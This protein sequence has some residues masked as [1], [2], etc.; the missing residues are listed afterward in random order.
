MTDVVARLTASLADRYRIERELGAG[1][2]ATVYLAY[3][4]RHE[5]RVALK[6]LRP[7]LAAVIGADRF[8]AE[9][10][11]TAHLQHAHILGLIDSGTVNGTVFYVMPF[12]EGESLRDRLDREKQLPVAD[13]VRIATTVAG[14]LDYAHRRGVI[15]RDIKPANILLH[16]GQALIADFGIALAITRTDTTTTGSRMT[17]TG[18]SLGTPQY[19]SPEQAMGERN[20]DAR[21][22]IYSL[23]CVLYE[24][25]SGEPPFSGPTAQAVF[26]KVMG[27]DP[28]PVT[29]LRRSVPANVGAATMTALNK[30]P[31]DRFAT[32]AEFSE[33]LGDARYVGLP[34]SRTRATAVAKPATATIVTSV[35]LAI[36][37][38]AAIAGWMRSSVVVK[39]LVARFEVPLPASASP[40]QFVVS[41]DGSRIFWGSGDAYFERRLDSL[42]SRRLRDA[43]VAQTGLRGISPDGREVLVGGFGGVAI[44]P[45]TQG[46]A[47]PIAGAG[48]GAAWGADNFIYF[49]FGSRA[50]PRGIARVRANGGAVDTLSVTGDMGVPADLIVLPGSKA[51]VVVLNRSTDVTIAA[52]DIVKKSWHPLGIS[53]SAVQF[54]APRYLV[55]ASGQYLM[56]APFDVKRL[57]VTQPSVPIAEA[58]GGSV[59]RFAVGGNVLAYLPAPDPLGVP[60]IA[61]RSRS[62]A[63]R[64]LPNVP[65]S[66]IFSAFT[67]SPDASRLAAVGTPRPAPGAS[68]FAQG[69][70]N[71][72]VFELASG[73]MSRWRSDLRESNPTW[74]PGGR[75][76]SFVRISADSP[77]TATLLR[78]PWDASAEAT[79]IYKYPGAV[80]G[81]GSPIGSAAWLSD[82]RAI[83]PLTRA[84]AGATNGRAAQGRGAAPTQNDLMIL[85]VVRGDSLSP[86]IVTDFSESNPVVSPDGRALAY[87][88]NESG[89]TEV[90]VRPVG[91]GALRQVS[92]SGGTQPKWA[93]SGRELFFRNADTLF[94]A[95][96]TSD[97]EVTGDRVTPVLSGGNLNSGYAV[98]PA[99][100]VFIMRASPTGQRPTTV[101]LIVV[102]NIAT[103]LDRIFGTTGRQG[104]P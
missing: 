95:R 68:P 97:G 94:A 41:G 77:S 66:I 69:V 90:Y 102:V 65:D 88:S 31:A 64:L 92:V 60:G 63:E 73:R 57:A 14:A 16:E 86:F 13:A 24:M 98:G 85:S 32:A 28:E 23:G 42:S 40:G 89:R 101:S 55:Y 9:I 76:L 17:E 30:V 36:A 50:T 21:T 70:S 6:V 20:I 78:R 91:G 54:V 62:A 4:V 5:R 29:T 82:G 46:P 96:V 10:K 7:E 27:V 11:T 43:A 59:E 93:R 79:P 56:A 35:L 15:H 75:E 83:I 19:M 49:S 84:M 38:V 3:D 44:A 25:L 51:L 37:I 52:F 74:M 80:G 72:Y 61:M 2:M 39:P 81:R 26:A 18:M 47:R 100:S 48:R 12:V 104:A 67:M 34:G 53:G 45:L 99:D 71:I 33:A 1:G 58:P 22:D 87:T 103:E 8:L